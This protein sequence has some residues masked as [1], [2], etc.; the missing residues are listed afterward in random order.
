MSVQTFEAL[1]NEKGE[2]QFAEFV[3]LP[4]HTKVYVVVPEQT[5]MVSNVVPVLTSNPV[6][7]RSEQVTAYSQIR[8]NA[9]TLD[10]SALHFP[11]V[12]V[13]DNELAKRLVKTIVG[14]ADARL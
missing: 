7:D 9:P 13:V 11:S 8:P 1:T 6:D 5:E 4:A 14:G 10:P 2:V 12:R 3:R